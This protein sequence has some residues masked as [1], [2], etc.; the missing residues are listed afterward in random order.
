MPHF[1]NYFMLLGMSAVLVRGTHGTDLTRTTGHRAKY[2]RWT[3]VCPIQRRS[4]G[5]VIPELL[6][7]R[8]CSL[9]WACQIQHTMQLIKPIL[10]GAVRSFVVREEASQKYNSW[11][12]KRQA[13][14]VWNFCDSYYRRESANGKNFATFPGP[15]SLFWWLARRPRFSDYETVSGERW[16]RAD[17][18]RVF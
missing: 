11:V 9:K 3:C 1:P 5:R 8:T 14:T 10:T 16:Q 2:C 4:A 18:K 13:V 17:L 12:Q 7:R 6:S 15:V